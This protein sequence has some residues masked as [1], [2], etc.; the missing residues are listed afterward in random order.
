MAHTG[1]PVCHTER[2]H[3]HSPGGTGCVPPGPGGAGMRVGLVFWAKAGCVTGAGWPRVPK[4]D[5]TAGLTT[6]HVDT[7]QS[8]CWTG[9]CCSQWLWRTEGPDTSFHRGSCLLRTA[10]LGLR[11]PRELQGPARAQVAPY[12]PLPSPEAAQRW[13]DNVL[14]VTRYPR[15]GRCY[16]WMPGALLSFPQVPGLPSPSAL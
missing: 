4:D 14:E 5:P 12:A 8:P 15:Q 2:K 11:S 6:H 9:P 3:P 13:S 10:R 1:P 7:R 16:C